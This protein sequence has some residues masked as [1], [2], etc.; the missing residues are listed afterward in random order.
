[1]LRDANKGTDDWIGK[2]AC[3]WS[4]FFAVIRSC[5]HTEIIEKTTRDSWENKKKC[6]LFVWCP[7]APHVSF[8]WPLSSVLQQPCKC[9]WTGKRLNHQCHWWSQWWCEGLLDWAFKGGT[10]LE[11]LVPYDH[12]FKER[13]LLIT[14][15]TVSE[16][17]SYQTWSTLWPTVPRHC[18]FESPAWEACTVHRLRE[19]GV[20]GKKW[21]KNGRK[22]L[23]QTK[24]LLIPTHVAYSV[25]WREGR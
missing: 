13:G 12:Y 6:F 9:E 24:M 1:M 5:S 3:L 21:Q 15:S 17:D 11:F 2:T 25:P 7:I 22:P 4:V 10:I 18:L 14:K 16:S 20:S 23:K 19:R 8:A